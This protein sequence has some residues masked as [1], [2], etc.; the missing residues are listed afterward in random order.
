MRGWTHL[1]RPLLSLP[2]DQVF[3]RLG[4]DAFPPGLAGYGG[5][6]GVGKNRIVMEG[7][8]HV[9]ICLEVRAGGDAEK[10]RFCV[11]GAKGAVLGDVHPGNIVANRFDAIA[12]FFQR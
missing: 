11:Y 5:H 10:S 7:R 4:T 2:I 6:G 1:R 8:H 3:A 9:G 12:F